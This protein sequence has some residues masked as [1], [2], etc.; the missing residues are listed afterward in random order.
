[1]KKQPNQFYKIK[2]GDKIDD[3]ALKYGVNSMKIL[4][5]N[6]ISPLNLKEGDY[7]FIDFS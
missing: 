6:N 3:I 4:I 1:M 7:L 2:N 5:I